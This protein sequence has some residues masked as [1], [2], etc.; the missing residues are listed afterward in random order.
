MGPE[1]TR[2]KELQDL[3][4]GSETECIEW[5]KN[6]VEWVVEGVGGGGVALAMGE[7]V[8]ADARV[9]L[10]GLLPRGLD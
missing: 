3:L 2:P 6:S 4:G 9:L 5:G 1:V 10:R 7:E 8:T